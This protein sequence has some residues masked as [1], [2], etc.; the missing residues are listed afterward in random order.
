MKVPVT[1]WLR[2]IPRPYW[3]LSSVEFMF[4]FATAAGNY[5]TVFLQKQGFVAAQVGFI[6]AVNSF[7]TIL[8]TPFWGMMADKIRSIR[9]VFVFCMGIAIVLWAF[10]PAS[11][12]I[13]AGP[14][15]LMFLVIPIITFFRN[16][17]SSLLDA[18]VVQR[19]DLDRVDYGHVRLW[20]SVSFAIMSI[21][22]SAFLPRIGVEIS[23]YLYGL[24][25]IPLLIIMGRMKEPDV[26]GP[27]KSLSFRQMGFG[28]LFKNY[29]LCT[30]M[31]F[32]VFLQIPVNS[33]LSFVPFL[34]ADVGGD[35]ALFGLFAGYKALLEIPMLLLMRRLRRKFPLPL[36]LASAC[37]F[38][39]TEALL[40]S[41]A[42]TLIKIFFIQT[43]HGLGGGLLIGAAANY[44]YSLAPPGLNST[45]Q[46]VYG[47]A[48]SI[49]AIIGNLGGGRL[50]AVIGIRPFYQV[51]FVV[52]FCA[53]AYFI[54]SL[55]FGIRVLKKAIP[56]SR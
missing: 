10:I 8:A 40:Y 41:Q 50:I 29:Y 43:F 45:A 20:G 13:Q 11:S 21:A 15:M 56:F 37:L 3:T 18:F 55:L 39:G 9:K 34:I 2:N 22:L 26:P 33:S 31:I 51:I 6:N 28:R 4:W 16:P 12:R 35:T 23:F 1:T 5:L 44:V 48:A 54:L 25:F 14:V 30:F 46:A 17:A 47:A 38:F 24:T 32:M 27:R 42:D 52:V 36:V 19:S 7:I 49:A 53:M